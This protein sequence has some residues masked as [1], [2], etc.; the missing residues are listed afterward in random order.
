MRSCEQRCPW[1]VRYMDV[2]TYSI[3]GSSSNAIRAVRANR[4]ELVWRDLEHLGL[5]LVRTGERLQ[6]TQRPRPAAAKAELNNLEEEQATTA[7]YRAA[8]CGRLVCLEVHLGPM[9]EL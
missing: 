2:V 6:Q 5:V 1:P 4:Y 8:S 7:V 3:R 9:G